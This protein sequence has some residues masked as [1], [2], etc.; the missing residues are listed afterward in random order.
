[1]VSWFDS[2][3][4]R[5]WWEK[6]SVIQ[7]GILIWFIIVPWLMRKDFRLWKENFFQSDGRRYRDFLFKN[8]HNSRLEDP[9]FDERILSNLMNLLE[10]WTSFSYGIDGPPKASFTQ[11]GVRDDPA[12]VN[13]RHLHAASILQSEEAPFLSVPFRSGHWTVRILIRSSARLAHLVCGRPNMTTAACFAPVCF[14]YVC[15]R[16]MQQ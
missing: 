5:D 2:L 11:M 13:C 3:Q 4:F 14:K 6:I 15:L 9:R 10:L 7:D 12:S 1:M 8:I 16:D